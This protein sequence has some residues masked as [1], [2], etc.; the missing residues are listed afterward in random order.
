VIKKLSAFASKIPPMKMASPTQKMQ[1]IRRLF[2]RVSLSAFVQ[3]ANEKRNKISHAS[4]HE[5]PT[6]NATIRRICLLPPSFESIE[7]SLAE[8]VV[9]VDLEVII[10]H[11]YGVSKGSDQ[12]ITPT[13]QKLHI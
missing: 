11:L 12:V 5:E 13:L 1:S 8:E 3:N 10:I 7:R 9:V 6:Q 2:S 4:K